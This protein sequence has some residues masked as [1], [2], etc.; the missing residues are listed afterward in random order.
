M[1][2]LESGT[3]NI[4][5]QMLLVISVAHLNERDLSAVRTSQSLGM[6]RGME[7][8]NFGFGI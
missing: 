7:I 4:I 6:E 5:Q 8:E 2:Y 1:S 3:C